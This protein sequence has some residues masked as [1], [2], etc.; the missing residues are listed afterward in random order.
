MRKYAEGTTVAVTRT[1]EEIE[2]LV[3]KYGAEA[4]AGGWQQGRA[5]VSFTM[6]GR[7][8]RFRLDLSPEPRKTQ[9]QRENEERRRWRCLLL[10]IK[11]KLE[12]VETGIATF[13]E[14]FLAHVVMPDDLT[15]WE[16][17]QL[18]EEGGRPMLPPLP[19]S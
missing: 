1:R 6:R 11:A 16:R 4:F 18:M 7:H 3:R 12:V 5:T 17:M 10:A 8:V 15:I 9:A 13:D 2:R 19:S 14:E